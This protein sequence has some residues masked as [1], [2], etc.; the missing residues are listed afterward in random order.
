MAGQSKSRNR[1]LSLYWLWEW[2]SPSVLPLAFKSI[3]EV[4][5][6]VCFLPW[7]TLTKALWE[8]SVG[9]WNTDPAGSGLVSRHILPLAIRTRSPKVSKH[10]LSAP[11]P[12]LCLKAPILTCR[13]ETWRQDCETH[14]SLRPNSIPWYMGTQS[15]SWKR[16]PPHQISISSTNLDNF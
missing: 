8:G 11:T 16:Q 4:S 10:F 12:Q 5:K 1:L 2:Y 3:S 7:M 14:H 15:S 9:P 6:P 13:W